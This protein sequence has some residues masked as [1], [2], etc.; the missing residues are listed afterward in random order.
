MNV[1]A[2]LIRAGVDPELVAKVAE[3][4]AE[5]RAKGAVAG[6]PQ[7]SRHA[8]AQ[9][10]Y[11]AACRQREPKGTPRPSSAEWI[12]LTAQAYERDGRVCSYCGDLDGPFAVDHV[13]P[14]AKGG[15]NDLSNLTVACRG[16]NSSKRDSL[17]EDWLARH[18]ADR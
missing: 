13:V 8:E 15:N 18:G 1:I 14:L 16:C 10:R 12:I 11:A 9:A 17:L 4:M 3:A 6:V 7:R 5:E 2:D